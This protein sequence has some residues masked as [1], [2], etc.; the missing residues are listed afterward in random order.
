MS[1]IV[2]TR[3]LV[4]VYSLAPLPL[5]QR[6]SFEPPADPYDGIAEVQEW[7]NELQ[8]VRYGDNDNQGAVINNDLL[9]INPFT[10]Y[11]CTVELDP[12]TLEVLDFEHP[13]AEHIAKKG[14][15][16]AWIEW[17]KEV[18]VNRMDENRV[19]KS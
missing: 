15:A 16:H 3:L 19:F 18:N 2:E 14:D 10:A 4:K 11:V 6:K 17:N 5:E 12:D 1:D 7:M 8:I 13:T 9:P